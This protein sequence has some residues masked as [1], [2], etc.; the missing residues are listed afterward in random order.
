MPSSSFIQSDRK[1]WHAIHVPFLYGFLSWLCRV[2]ATCLV[3]LEAMAT[4]FA[5][6]K[7]VKIASKTN[8]TLAVGAP[9]ATHIFVC[10]EWHRGKV[11]ENWFHRF[12]RILLMHMQARW[13]TRRFNL[14][15]CFL[16]NEW[17]N[18]HRFSIRMVA[19]WTPCGSN[20][21]NSNYKVFGHS[22]CRIVCL[23]NFM[24]VNPLCFSLFSPS[25]RTN[26]GRLMK[27]ERHTFLVS[28]PMGHLFPIDV[29]SL[30]KS[31]AT[32]RGHK[33]QQR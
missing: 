20:P 33:K 31:S 10:V 5:W 29:I 26:D 32:T 27:L 12:S 2:P 14:E 9:P 24:E 16:N 8:N 23:F 7:S 13:K 11:E 4:R 17:L 3:L 18:K 21:R 22:F 19:T 6:L 28:V 30:P 25:A 1:S 15:P